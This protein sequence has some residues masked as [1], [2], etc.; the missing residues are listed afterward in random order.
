MTTLERIYHLLNNAIG[1][2]ENGDLQEW[3]PEREAKEL[4]QELHPLAFPNPP[5]SL[6]PDEQFAQFVF[7]HFGGHWIRKGYER[8]QMAKL[9]DRISRRVDVL[10]REHRAACEHYRG[11]RTGV[12][13]KCGSPDET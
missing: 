13:V 5:S 2:E 12:C 11:V 3:F 4:L 7:A 1:H 10:A 6:H 9:P 8:T